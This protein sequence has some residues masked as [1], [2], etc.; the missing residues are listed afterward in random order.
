MTSYL[1]YANKYL[2][3]HKKKTK[4]AVISVAIA[5]TLVVSIF[6]MLDSLIKFEK[7][8]ALKSQGN[9]HITIMNP[10][11]SETTYIN[12]RIEVKNTG[13]LRE[14]NN[15]KI[16]GSECG[17]ASLDEKFVKNLNINLAEGTYPT[18][19]NEIMLER[20][21]MEK[22]KL[23]I[24]DTVS[25]ILSNS[26]KTEF[27][28]SG[29]YKDLS[30]TKA[31][32]IPIVFLS[33]NMSNTLTP[34]H[35]Q[36]YILF[37]TGVNIKNTENIIKKDLNLNSNRIARNEVLLGL[38]GQS[39]NGA[40]TKFYAIGSILFFLVLVTAVAMIYNTFNISVMERVKQF[41]ILR[42]IGTSKKQIRKLVRREGL[43]ISLKA[44]PIG[45]IAGTIFSFIC[46]AILKYFNPKIYG[47]I[48]IFNFSITGIILGIVIGFL[49]V[50]IASLSPAKK[51][52]NIS[53]VNA[54]NGSNEIKISKKKKKGLLTK[55]FPVD[56]SIGINNA[57]S[58]KKTLFL[59][60][61]S[62][63]LSI[64]L[65]MGFSVLVNPKP[66]GLTPINS[67]TP[68]IKIT[69]AN[70]ISK[71]MYS[72]LSNAE[73]IKKVRSSISKDGKYNTIE[74]QLKNNKDEETVKK[75]QSMITSDT[76]QFHDIR[77]LNAEAKSAFIT[78]AVFIYSF[79]GIIA[80]ISILNIVNTMNTSVETK[81][82]Y[83]GVMRA[84]G[85]SGNQVSHMVLTQAFIYSLSGSIL[86]CILGTLLQRTLS[87]ILMP[88]DW[89]FPLLQIVMIFICY[90]LVS[91]AS[92]INP[93]KRI[94]TNAISEVVTS[95]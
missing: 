63:A 72:K 59:M 94:K 68:D 11:S 62:I 71:D 53:P 75:L 52:S 47:N 44:I 5:V 89:K 23:K 19:E 95:L 49:T 36:I 39:N 65:F 45:I 24:G 91:A 29:A 8:Q 41:G 9:Y 7:A 32:G 57:V 70:V 54:V 51:A 79:V 46:S 81:Q 80:L 22:S 18:K 25:L 74:I 77:E 67:S 28:V 64:I 35:S 83:L 38:M 30:S 17:F 40:L 33:T 42:C 1:A 13:T 48:S 50:I 12:N 61:L 34:V 3:V 93:L 2:S 90:S 10:S 87:N 56:I 21:F 84:I 16:N 27:I 31:A 82:K 66:L 20:W 26:K 88:G 85:M 4:F 92:V 37:K 76:M 58:K 60:S 78:A 43:Y 15:G 86:G 14:F 55:I 6:S 69:S 73:G